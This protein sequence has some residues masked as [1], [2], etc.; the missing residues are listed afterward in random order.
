MV[1]ETGAVLSTKANSN[2]AKL[3]PQQREALYSNPTLSAMS[4]DAGLAAAIQNA[5]GMAKPEMSYLD[6][7][8]NAVVIYSK[9][10]Y[11]RPS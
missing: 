11:Q 6:Q 7:M 5:P 8:S 3:T 10:T 2:I 9:N 4:N 1:G